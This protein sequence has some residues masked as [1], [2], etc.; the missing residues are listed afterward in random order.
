MYAIINATTYDFETY[1][2]NQYI[3]FDK[4][5]LEVGNMS[6]YINNDYE[7]ID[8][9][10]N[11]VM[12]GLVNGHSHIYS[13][14][15]RGLNVPYNPKDF[16]E[17]LEQ[18]WWKLDR[19][20]DNDITYYSGIVAGIE[21]LQHGVTSIIDHHAS[22]EVLQ[23]L[24]SL[25]KAVT[26]MVGIRG[27]YCFET[28]DRF[29]IKHCVQENN[30]FIKK[31]HTSRSQGLFGLHAQF[32]LSDESLEY[33]SNECHSPIHVHVA[34]SKMDQDL[35]LSQHNKRVIE[36]LHNYNLIRQDSILTHAIYVDEKEL[37]IIKQQEAVVAFNVTSNMNNGVGLPN[38]SQFKEKNIPVIIGNDGIS[39]SIASE[40]RNL[41]FAM[42]HNSQTPTTFSYRDLL[43]IINNTYQYASRRLGTKLGRIQQEY[44]ADL[45]IV[46]H[47][48]IAHLTTENVFGYLLFGLFQDF[49]P[50]DVF[51]KGKQ[52]LDNYQVNTELNK[53]YHD[54]KKYST[55][56]IRNIEK[57]GLL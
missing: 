53:Q 19:N 47:T 27:I 31:N 13:T 2:K 25:K 56:L 35:C 54:A 3:L 22:G 39:N 51:I 21:Y 4:T 12:P 45:V 40:Y 6:N 57:E 26:E 36:R 33:I 46:Q 9:L 23:S 49:T 5:I 17:I 37:D 18:L 55:I 1:Q 11:L 30:Q 20:I 38:Y 29:N 44:A 8:A 16:K 48:P 32:T 28:S 41:F 42:H 10:S 34:E 15:A 43:D 14:F 50:S 24:A 52:V 7:E